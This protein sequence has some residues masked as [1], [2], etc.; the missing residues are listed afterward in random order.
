M[1]IEIQIRC[2]STWPT[3]EELALRNDLEDW[4][5]GNIGSVVGCG[6]GMGAMDISL[7]TSDDEENVTRIRDRVRQLGLEK[8]TEIKTMD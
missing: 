6:G 7:N 4:L 1:R 2:E 8:I 5:N 3:R